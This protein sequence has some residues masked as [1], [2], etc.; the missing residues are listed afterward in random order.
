MAPGYPPPTF[1]SLE[2]GLAWYDDERAN[3]VAATR[4]AAA[5]GLHEIAWRIPPTLTP[6]FYRWSNW[7]DCVTTHRIALESARLAGDRP[8]K[9]GRLTSSGFALAR[10]RDEEAFTRLEQALTIRRELGDTKGEAQSAIG[11]AEGYL[12]MHGPGENALR[13]MQLAVDLLRPTGATSMLAAALNNLGEVYLGL[14]DL[15]AAK[16][17]YIHAHDICRVIG[18]HVEGHTLHNLGRVYQF[19][20]RPTRR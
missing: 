12:N 7:A 17:C 13:Y 11:L 20:H 4:Q 3:I 5:V 14:G 15:G 8:A 19:Q 1:A 10:L 18:G 6:L 16:E 9:P 2:E